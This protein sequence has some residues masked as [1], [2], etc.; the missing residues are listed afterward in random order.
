M[1]GGARVVL[2]RKEKSKE[3]SVLA[4]IWKVDLCET[5]EIGNISQRKEKYKRKMKV[6]NKPKKE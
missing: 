3:K 5:C 4:C 1:I 6:K 2:S